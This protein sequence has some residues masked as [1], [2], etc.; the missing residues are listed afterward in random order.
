MKNVLFPA[1]VPVDSE[2]SNATRTMYIA[3]FQKSDFCVSDT[4]NRLVRGVVA[5]CA[6]DMAAKILY[7]SLF[8][9]LDLPP[10]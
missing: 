10:S 9:V 2:D 1:C 7:A 4:A 3:H 5:A 8:P 6:F